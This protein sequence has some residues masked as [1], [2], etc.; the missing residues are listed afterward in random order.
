[1]KKKDTKKTIRNVCPSIYIIEVIL[2][3]KET[4][5]K[6][7]FTDVDDNSRPNG[8]V[9][10]YKEQ[11]PNN[12][13]NL[14]KVFQLPL[15]HKKYFDDDMVRAEL[16]VLDFLNIKSVDPAYIACN[17][18]VDGK[19]EFVEVLDSSLNIITEVER[20]IKSLAQNK[21]N[22]KYNV[23]NILRYDPGQQHLVNC[24]LITHIEQKLKY[25]VS[26]LVNKNILLIGQFE[27]EWLSTFVLHNNVYCICDD[28]DQRPTFKYQPL[29]DRITYKN[30]IEEII[31][32]HIDF[33]LILSNP[34]YSS[35]GANI[36]DTIKNEITYKEFANLLPANDYKRNEGKDLFKYAREMEAI[37]DG[38]ADA[39]VT[40][41]LALIVKQP[42]NM[43]LDEFEISNY[44]DR[45]LDLFFT[46]QR[47]RSHYAI[48]TATYK[49]KL[50]G[51]AQKFDLRKCIFI[52]KRYISD[53]HL[54]YTKDCA[55]YKVN[56]EHSL[57][58]QGL[59]DI[60]A[61]S[62]QANG[63]V[64]D[65]M[66]VQFNTDQEQDNIAEWLYSQEGY[67][68][69]SK[70]LV[71]MNADS[72]CSVSYFLPKVDWTRKWTTT[73]ILLNY[74]YTQDK[75]DAILA[76]LARFKYMKD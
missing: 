41:H 11:N 44:I 53:E 67:R 69:F 59:I 64:G 33:D 28:A 3:N 70:I 16:Y 51:F 58:H 71:A 6:V 4:Y 39:A 32:M 72:Y 45:D 54:P 18:G 47:K 60:S 48:D 50:V 61:K 27:P 68:M 40:T 35:I 17:I 73:E 36:T 52:G 7:G 56:V 19:N 34:P 37:N 13:I 38:F 5:Y 25:N 49:P 74:G 8:L 76:D 46:E 55:G 42:N 10:K 29:N 30:N 14:L 21:D 23:R 22:F 26:D 1:M 63:N 57:D 66:L 65:F 62:E 9:K 2:A 24:N 75:I 20:A 12:T 43:T 31:D 15:Y